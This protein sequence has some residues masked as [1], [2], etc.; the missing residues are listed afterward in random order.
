MRPRRE[1][2]AAVDDDVR[3]RP[4]RRG[5]AGTTCAT[6][7]A[8]WTGEP[9]QPYCSRVEAAGRSRTARRRAC[10]RGPQPRRRSA[11]RG[12]EE[13]LVGDV[14][15]DHRHVD[16]A[17]EHALRGLG[18]GPDVELG[19]RRDVALGDRA[20]HEDDPLEPVGCLGVAGEQQR[21][22]RQRAGRDQRHRL[23]RRVSSGREEVDGVLDD[24]ARPSA[25]GRSGPSMPVS[26]WTW[27]RR[28]GSRTS[29]RRRP[30]ATGT[31]PRPTNSSTRSAFAVVFSR[32]WLPATVVM[33]R[34]STSGLASASSSAI[35]SS[36]PGSQSRRIGVGHRPEDR[37]DLG[38]GGQ[39]RLRARPGSRERAGRAG[40]AQRLVARRGP[41]A[42]E[43][44]RQAVNASPA[45]VPSTASTARRLGARDLAAVLEQHRALGAERQ[46]DERRG[47]RRPRARSGSRRAGRASTSTAARAPRSGRRTRRARPRCT[48][49]SGISSWQSTAPPRDRRPPHVTARSRRARRRSGSRRA[50]STR[51]SATP[52]RARPRAHAR[53]RRRP[54]RGRRAPPRRTR[55]RRPRR[56][57]ARPR[58]AAR[59]RPP[60]S[61]PCRPGRGRSRAADRLPRRGRRSTRATRSRL[62]EPTTRSG[63]GSSRL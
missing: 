9:S 44:T 23:R 22:V 8:S 60:G 56:R 18:V 25:R 63:R 42:S 24:R 19:G 41:R 54:P 51:I 43:T 11:C 59:P 36:W 55:R 16:P 17:R 15:A 39:R 26:P 10:R 47:A 50:S 35:A 21:D 46:R 12:P 34:R 45:A 38:G 61:R 20:A 49:S 7:T 62:I 33:P 53:A 5:R 13:R 52:G 30:A 31:S 32:V 27:R 37:V 3:G 1:L 28:R 4:C 58:R 29:G 48:A 40:A 6:A 2:A 14:E 57:S